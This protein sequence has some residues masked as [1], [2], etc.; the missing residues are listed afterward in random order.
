MPRRNQANVSAA[1]VLHPVAGFLA[2]PIDLVL[3]LAM[4]Y[5]WVSL[6]I[7]GIWLA[8]LIVIFAR[9]V[10]AENVFI[11]SAFTVV[12][13]FPDF[14]HPLSFVP[15]IQFSGTLEML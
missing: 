7:C 3:Y 14:Y 13:L 2:C 11:F 15:E 8:N 9:N 12:L 1:A 6:A 10:N 4:R 5:P